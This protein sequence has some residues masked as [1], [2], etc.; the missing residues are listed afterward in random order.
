MGGALLY[1]AARRLTTLPTHG[2]SSALGLGTFLLAVS[3]PFEGLLI[4]GPVG[5][6]LLWWLV[7]DR[8]ST[9]ARRVLWLTPGLLVS[10]AGLAW[11]A[12]YNWRGTGDALQLPYTVYRDRYQMLPIFRW[13]EVRP[14]PP[15][16][17]QEMLNYAYLELDA[18]KMFSQPARRLADY[19]RVLAGETGLLTAVLCVLM[20]PWT[21]R[22]RSLWLVFASSAVIL[23]G[24]WFSYYFEFHYHAPAAVLTLI[25]ATASLRRLALFRKGP[26]SLYAVI[27]AGIL[28]VTAVQS[29]R[30]WTRWEN[31]PK[32]ILQHWAVTRQE[33]IDT[34]TRGG[35]RHV[36]FVKYG[37]RHSPHAEVV[38]NTADVDAQTVV[39]V[40][41]L[42]DWQ[43]QEVLEYYRDRAAWLMLIEDDNGYAKVVP[44][45]RPH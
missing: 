31:M 34:L 39:W 22:A 16:L 8:R 9:L 11:I 6:Y 28:L 5:V 36:V 35:G 45:P 18:G 19:A 2:A 4:C 41:A 29:F 43:N 14:L 42:E 7:R 1:G 15:N 26:R 37:P 10:A 21:L 25:L 27:V 24:M 13:Q 3:R 17:N 44:F 32:R 23:S 33:V 40:R 12:Y 38:H 30:A 20:L